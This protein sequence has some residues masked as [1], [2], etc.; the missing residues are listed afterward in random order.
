MRAC[1]SARAPRAEEVIS[2][3]NGDDV[4]DPASSSEEELLGLLHREAAGD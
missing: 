4:L 3:A 1:N 2:A